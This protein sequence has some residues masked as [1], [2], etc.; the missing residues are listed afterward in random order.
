MSERWTGSGHLRVPPMQPIRVIVA[1]DHGLVRAGVRN[2]LADIPGVEVVAEAGDG[3]RARELAV[4]HRPH[5]LLADVSM[6][7]LGGLELAERLAHELPEVRVVMLSMHAG[8]EYIARALR[9]G[10]AG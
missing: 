10:A 5:V 1:D 2:L 9:A 3:E 7:R 4:A 8:Q 6:P